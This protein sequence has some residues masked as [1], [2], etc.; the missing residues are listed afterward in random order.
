MS[1]IRSLFHRRRRTGPVRVGPFLMSLGHQVAYDEIPEDVLLVEA[2]HD[3]DEGLWWLAL[4]QLDL[5]VSNEKLEPMIDL[6]LTYVLD[7]Y[8]VLRSI[9][10]DELTSA[11]RDQLAAY[12]RAVLPWFLGRLR[13]AAPPLSEVRRHLVPA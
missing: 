13:Q 1:V 10:P 8:G 2:R 11:E 12:E 6:L 5:E 9:A 7:Y 4:P 3:D